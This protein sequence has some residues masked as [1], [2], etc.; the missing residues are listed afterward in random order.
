MIK[1]SAIKTSQMM[2]KAVARLPR[3]MLM[4]GQLKNRRPTTNSNI[5]ISRFN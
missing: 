5:Q 1:M 3:K 2:N 4:M